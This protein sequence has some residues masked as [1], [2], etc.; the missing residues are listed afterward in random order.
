M[1]SI[2]IHSKLLI[3]LVITLTG[4]IIIGLYYKQSPEFPY[5]DEMRLATEKAQEWFNLI[6][7]MKTEK[8]IKSDTRSS[9]PNHFMIGNEW[10]DITTSLGSLQAKETSTNP[11]FAALVVRLLHEADMD[12]NDTI[13]IILS[14]SFPSLAVTVLAALQTLEIEA[15]VISSLGAS[16]YGANQ[17]GATWIDMEH[18]LIRKGGLKYHSELLTLGGENDNASWIGDQGKSQLLMAA[19]RNQKDLFTSSSIVESVESKTDLFLSKH[20]SLLINIGGNMSALGTCSHSINIPNGLNFTMKNC[21]DENKGVIARINK[22]G[23]PFIHFLDIQDIAIR[24][25]MDFSPGNTYAEA[26]NLYTKKND[27]ETLPIIILLCCL[28]P[29]IILKK[30]YN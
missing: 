10:S 3:V 2:G 23:I 9:V 22:S 8:G 17:P 6:D 21:D 20:I 19:R 1:K 16:T 5:A 13:G 11:E 18:Y 28:M 14:G 24:Y 7:Q 30:K 26:I 4:T 12:K 15:V 27:N 29:I 25:G